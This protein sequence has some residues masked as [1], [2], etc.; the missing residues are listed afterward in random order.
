MPADVRASPRR[1]KCG[2]EFPSGFRVLQLSHP[3]NSI[4]AS[5][6]VAWDRNKCARAIRSWEGKSRTQPN[7]A[8]ASSTCHT[9]FSFLRF[10]SSLKALP[11]PTRYPCASRW[12][13]NGGLWFP[14]FTL[15]YQQLPGATTAFHGVLVLR[16]HRC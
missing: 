5:S 8:W 7:I 9:C 11:A 15:Q 12:L 6:S 4:A 16:N 3:P 10:A 2:Q 13:A 14:C 1:C